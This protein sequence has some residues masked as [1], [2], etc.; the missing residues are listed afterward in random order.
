[1]FWNRRQRIAPE[2]LAEALVSELIG[3]AA[4]NMTK[5][6]ALEGEALARFDLNARR[7]AIASVLLALGREERKNS[8]FAAVR[9][10]LERRVFPQS[11]TAEGIAL[12]GGVKRAMAHLSELLFPKAQPTQ[13]T[14]ARDWLREIG[15][16][17]SNPVTL[18]LLAIYWMDYHITASKALQSFKVI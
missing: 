18:S 12:L 5:H 7:Y 14:W 10:E 9:A 16:D 1:M 15:V 2:E 11:L 6:F 4:S 17:E 13:I 8:R 3:A